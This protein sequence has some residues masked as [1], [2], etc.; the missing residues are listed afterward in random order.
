MGR[1]E[2]IERNLISR[3]AVEFS[4]FTQGEVLEQLEHA[5]KCASLGDINGIN[6][7][8]LPAL[9][10]H[11][12]SLLALNIRKAASI[13]IQELRRQRD[14]FPNNEAEITIEIKTVFRV[15]DH[16]FGAEPRKI[17]READPQFR[18]SYEEKVGLEFSLTQGVVEAIDPKN[19]PALSGL[20]SD[21]VE[22]L[23]KHASIINEENQKRLHGNDRKTGYD[24]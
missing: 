9:M 17:I 20:N 6:F 12:Q 4:I 14:V 13:R 19:F 8:N 7:K 1:K 24:T 21:T 16:I 3:G 22:N 15:V 18:L 11:D 10:F 23:K 2:D 5:A